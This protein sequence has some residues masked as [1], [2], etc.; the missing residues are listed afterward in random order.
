[1]RLLETHCPTAQAFIRLLSCWLS[2]LEVGVVQAQPVRQNALRQPPG[3]A[4]FAQRIG[5]TT[6]LKW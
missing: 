3:V 2:L 4:F 5:I 6:W 1:M